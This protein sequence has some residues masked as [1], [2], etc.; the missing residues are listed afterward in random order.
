LRCQ[1]CNRKAI[2][3][4]RSRHPESLRDLLPRRLY[5][6]YKNQFGRIGIVAGSRGFT[7]AAVM[8]SLGALR[9]GAGLV[10]LFVLEEVYQLVAAAAAPEVMVKPVKSYRSLLK[11]P[12]TSGRSDPVWAKNAPQKS[13][14]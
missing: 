12:A 6:S 13:F 8:C 3:E 2:G 10:E 5:S 14:A 4:G 9:A 7:G 11:E 1:S